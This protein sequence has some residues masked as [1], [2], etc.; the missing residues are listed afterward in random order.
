MYGEEE[1]DLSYQAIEA[2]F[3]ILY[4]PAV[5]IHHYPRPPVVDHKDGYRQPEFI[6]SYSQSLLLILQIPTLALHSRLSYHLV[7]Q[8]WLN[9]LEIDGPEGVSYPV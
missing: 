4:L 7:E 8:I 9:R 6:L 1:L 5:E 2:G 3:D